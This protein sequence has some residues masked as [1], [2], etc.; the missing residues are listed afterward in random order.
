[1]KGIRKKRYDTIMMVIIF[2]LFFMLGIIL[3]IIFFNG[4][5]YRVELLSDSAIKNLSKMTWNNKVLFYQCLLKRTIVVIVLP[6][7]TLTGL[8]LWAAGLYTA[9][10]SFS[11]GALME[12]LTLEY[13]FSGL[14]LFVVGIFPHYLF[15][16]PAYILLFR[17]CFQMDIDKKQMKGYSPKIKLMNTCNI[18]KV[19]GIILGVVIIGTLFESYV[20]PIL[21]KEFSNLFLG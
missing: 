1:M 2:F 21:L 5:G 14:L 20:N 9:W 15:Y 10:F 12:I 4:Y 19:I 7:L 3:V 11:M 16:I 8:G 17:L 6:L 13:G 18:L